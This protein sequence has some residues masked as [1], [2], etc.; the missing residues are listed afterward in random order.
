MAPVR[1]RANDDA[2]GVEASRKVGLAEERSHEEVHMPITRQC[3]LY[4]GWATASTRS[5]RADEG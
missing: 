5:P 1:V 4:L 3:S 2:S